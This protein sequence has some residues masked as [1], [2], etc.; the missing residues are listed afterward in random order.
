MPCVSQIEMCSTT[1]G[2]SDPLSPTRKHY[3]HFVETALTIST[4]ISYEYTTYLNIAEDGCVISFPSLLCFQ[5]STQWSVEWETLKQTMR[6]YYN[7][8]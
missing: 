4:I 5:L 3:E 2:Q 7:L 8:T 1:D 6:L